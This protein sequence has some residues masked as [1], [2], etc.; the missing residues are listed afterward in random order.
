MQSGSRS[1]TVHTLAI[2]NACNQ[3]RDMRA[4]IANRKCPILDERFAGEFLVSGAKAAVDNSH[5]LPGTSEP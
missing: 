3:R 4:V 2:L 1:D 5:K